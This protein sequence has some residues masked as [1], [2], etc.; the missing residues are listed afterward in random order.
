MF[1]IKSQKAKG[2]IGKL[3]NCNMLSFTFMHVAY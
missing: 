3:G 2:L 1:K